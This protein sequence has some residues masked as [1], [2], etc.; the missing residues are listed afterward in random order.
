[1]DVMF[2]S[3][4]VGSFSLEKPAKFVA[5]NYDIAVSVYGLLKADQVEL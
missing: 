5:F 2:V 1:M 3:R 4:S